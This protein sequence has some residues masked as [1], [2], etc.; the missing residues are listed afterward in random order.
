MAAKGLAIFAVVFLGLSAAFLFAGSANADTST[1]PTTAASDPANLG[2]SSVPAGPGPSVCTPLGLPASCSAADVNNKLAEQAAAATAAQ[3][4]AADAQAA[5]NAKIAADA[6]ASA[7][8]QAKASAAA[9]SASAA[10]PSTDSVAYASASESAWPTYTATSSAPISNPMTDSAQA[11]QQNADLNVQRTSGGTNI[12]TLVLV[13]LAVVVVAGGALAI[14]MLNR[15]QA[16]R[17]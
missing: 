15:R 6:Q 11:P 4:A 9:A 10:M 8:A 14:F 7:D 17:H 16:G 1:A 12:L 13:L 3:K 2:G 5:L